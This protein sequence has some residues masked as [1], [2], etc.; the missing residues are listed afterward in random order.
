[1][2]AKEVKLFQEVAVSI[3]NQLS[4]REGNTMRQNESQPFFAPQ[5][6][7]FLLTFIFCLSIGS[8]EASTVKTYGFNEPTKYV[9]DKANYTQ[10]LEA[11]DLVRRGS[12]SGYINVAPYPWQYMVWMY[13][14]SRLI[15]DFTAFGDT[16]AV[17]FSFSD[18]NDGIANIY[19][20]GQRVTSLNTQNQSNFYVEV[21]DLPFT[22]HK[23]IVET[24]SR[25]LHVDAIA[26]RATNN[27]P[28]ANAGPDQAVN[29]FSSVTLDG[30]AS[31]DPE[32]NPLIFQWT[33]LNGTQVVLNITDQS[34][35]TFSTPA[36]SRGGETLTFQLT[37]NDGTLSSTADIVN[38]SIKDVNR[39][40]VADAGIDLTVGEN[41]EVV[42]DSAFSYDP[43][44]DQLSYDWFQVEGPSVA[45]SNLTS[46]KLVFTTPFVGVLGT[47]LKFEL[48][49][50]DGIESVID[51]VDVFVE[52]VNHAPVANAG[53]NQTRNEGGTVKLDGSTSYDV[54]DDL[55]TYTW[56][57]INGFPV[58]LTDIHGQTPEFSAP[59]VELEG[60]TLVF[61][62]V[63]NDGFVDSI[64]AEV[65]I[66]VLDINS[67]PS[68][69]TAV[70]HPMAMWPPN[71]KLI[72]IDIT[73]ISDP[74]NDQVTVT[75]LNVT[76]DEPIDGLGDGDTA[77][78][79]VIQG[80]E[81][82]LR[83]ERAGNGNGRTYH[84]TFRADD[85]FG[86]SCTGDLSVFVPHDRNSG[87]ID[88]GQEYNSLVP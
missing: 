45:L 76:Q 72:P 29:E 26:V 51:T 71:H 16:V 1:M 8:V 12:Y 5:L 20:D 62:L 28:V 43:D 35:P 77:P 49:V 10:V 73:G 39:A 74:D 31:I 3:R 87:S 81:L 46:A 18:S 34:H 67:P 13:S 11:E 6:I 83:A 48:A 64:P 9:F 68:C 63:V 23:V 57:Q 21:S 15:A 50:S 79:A 86:E 58:M 84:I 33:Q 2:R 59:L 80:S 66:S 75:F 53:T 52:N 42:L 36:V 27:P 88:D 70:A 38:V 32:G 7:L 44:G 61:Q 14:G 25:D 19:V 37:V 60:S 56:T 69:G 22:R 30:S 78:D 85:S 65:I 47:T 41:S 82:L 55:L 40:P 17:Q 4:Y 24:V 54:D